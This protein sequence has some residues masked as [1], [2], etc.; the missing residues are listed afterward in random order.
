MNSNE[1]LNQE[2]DEFINMEKWIKKIKSSDI[3]F[4]SNLLKHADETIMPLDYIHAMKVIPT[5]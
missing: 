1:Y 5:E 3:Q 2:K 4:N